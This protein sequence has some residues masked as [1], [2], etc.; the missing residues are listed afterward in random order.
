M[1]FQTFLT[2]THVLDRKFFICVFYMLKQHDNMKHRQHY[3]QMVV[4]GGWKFHIWCNLIPDNLYV[5][6]KLGMFHLRL[7]VT[8]TG[9]SMIIASLWILRM[10]PLIN[11][12]LM[13]S[14]TFL[15]KKKEEVFSIDATI[16]KSIKILCSIKS[17]TIQWSQ[18]S[19]Y[20]EM[21]Y[22][23]SLWWWWFVCYNKLIQLI[24]ENI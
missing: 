11:V 1:F 13:T 6:S 23:S 24:T 3:I 16:H 19:Y 15:F 18:H 14:A 2:P 20:A 8:G 9:S 17:F 5:Y 4:Y 21:E 22:R 12:D 10:F 7:S